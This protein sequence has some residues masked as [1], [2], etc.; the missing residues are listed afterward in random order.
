MN[1]VRTSGVKVRGSARRSRG[2]VPS[3][4]RAIRIL[5]AVGAAVHPPTLG[6]LARALGIPKSSLHDLCATLLQERLLE[7]TDGG[8]FRIGV[9]VLDFYRAYDTTT[10]LGTEFH[11]VCEELVPR[12][13]ETIVLSVLDGREVVYVACRNGTQPIAVNY[14]IGLRLPAHTTATGKAILSTLREEE[15]RA[16]FSG[17]PLVRP[18]RHSIGRVE[19]LLEELRITRARGYS[20]D[21]EETVE[22]M[23]CVGAPLCA[24][25][26]V[27]AGI[28]FSMVKA[29]TRR[30]R[31][32]DLGRKIQHL[33][34]VLSERLG[35]CV[36]A[37]LSRA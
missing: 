26:D 16:L 33:A 24:P 17:Q 10:H 12:H 13:E 18:T 7:R 6:E 1:P 34:A 2:I 27:R 30:G 4:L 28:A 22:G 3:V 5:E 32:Q 15:V 20:V 14:R 29:R 37:R 21:D 11:R 31:F 8:G 23:S 19:E 9:R 35:G 25:G 36:P